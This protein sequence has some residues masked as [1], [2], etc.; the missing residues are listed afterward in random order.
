MRSLEMAEEKCP[1]NFKLW[2]AFLAGMVL[3]VITAVAFDWV[4]RGKLRLGPPGEGPAPVMTN[5][6]SQN[7]D[8]RIESAET[9]TRAWLGVDVRDIGEESDAIEGVL[10]ENVTHDSPADKAGLQRGDIILNF[11]R[12]KTPAVA[13]IQ[14]LVQDTTPGQRVRLTVNR[15]GKR[16]IL[17]VKMEEVTN[18][19]SLSTQSPNPLI[20]QSPNH[21]MS[22]VS[23]D[24]GLVVAPAEKG[25]MVMQVEPGSIA[26]RAGFQPGDIIIGVNGKGT[27]D[28]RSFFAALREDSRQSASIVFDVS[29]N[30]Q[31]LYLFLRQEGKR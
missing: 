7:L 5:L 20:T 24:W 26:S 8:T 10:V 19:N 29:R 31:N 28:M 21:P 12:R 15:H 9:S 2:L 25:V 27:P 14:S 4:S 11:D 1:Q 22:P 18:R 23:Q 13:N 3:M 30:S 6:I 17:Y 16:E